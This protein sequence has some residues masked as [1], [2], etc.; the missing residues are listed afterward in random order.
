VIASC[1][2]SRQRRLKRSITDTE[3]YQVD[4][5]VEIIE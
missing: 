5:P 4:R 3:Q 2:R 1:R